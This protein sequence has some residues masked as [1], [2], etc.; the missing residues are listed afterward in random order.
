[1]DAARTSIYVHTNYSTREPPPQLTG[2][3]IRRGW[4]PDEVPGGRVTVETMQTRLA[5]AQRARG[6]RR[7]WNL[8]QV[9]KYEW[10]LSRLVADRVEGIGDLD[11]PWILA[12]TDTIFVCGAAEL[13]R[14]FRQ[15][16]TDLVISAEKQRRGIHSPLPSF[17][18]EGD[19]STYWMPMQPPSQPNSGLIMGTFKGAL[20]LLRAMRA[21]R[22]D[23]GVF[24]CC[25]LMHSNGSMA[26][27]RCAADDQICVYAA[28]RYSKEEGGR[29]R[30][31][32]LDYALDTNASLFA[33][34][35][36]WQDT[37]KMVRYW[38]GPDGKRVMGYRLRDH[39]NATVTP[40]VWHLA[41]L[42]KVVL[43]NM[44]ITER[45]AGPST[46]MPWNV[47]YDHFDRRFTRTGGRERAQKR[48]SQHSAE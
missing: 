6:I 24:P 26:R 11:E 37:H 38:N 21:L 40:C 34:L 19:T 35:S 15:F 39:P 48:K 16:G 27:G 33:T 17:T 7:A 10:L 43:S 44:M 14:R 45:M 3:R 28:L 32:D 30:S 22:N 41:G 25:P 9:Y 8:L 29:P 31:A 36:A 12:D 20:Q 18:G 46:W 23:V 2:L 13:N 1:M 5:D 4:Y 47:S 42:G